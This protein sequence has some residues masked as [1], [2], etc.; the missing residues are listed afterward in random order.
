MEDEFEKVNEAATFIAHEAG[1]MMIDLCGDKL[2]EISGEQE[3]SRGSYVGL[4]MLALVKMSG[5]IVE[6]ACQTSNLGKRDKE[7][8]RN[9][10]IDMVQDNFDSYDRMMDETTFSVGLN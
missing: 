4:M 6:T 5:A 3:F 9:K 1:N 10:F 2:K 7:F 8:L